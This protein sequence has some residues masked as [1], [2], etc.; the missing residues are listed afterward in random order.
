MKT[1][2]I[3]IARAKRDLSEGTDNVYWSEL[4]LDNDSD[5]A[6][7]RYLSAVRRAEALGFSYRSAHDLKQL[8]LDDIVD[9]FE[10][11]LPH[12]NDRQI[13]D[14]PLGVEIAPAAVISEAETIRL[15]EITPHLLTRKSP[16]Q[17]K[18]WLNERRSSIAFLVAQVGDKDIFA[19]NR[20]DALR[21]YRNLINMVLQQTGKTARSASWA[22][23]HLG[24]IRKFI[25]SY[26]SHI[27]QPDRMN[28]FSCL[29][30]REFKATRPPFSVK[31]ICEK[32]LIP[33]ALD[34]L[35][36]EAK[37]ILLTL[38]DTGARMGE[39]CSLSAENTH[40]DCDYPYIDIKPRTDP[41]NPREIK[42]DSSI[43]TVP[44]IGLALTAMKHNPEG[45][46]RY[47]DK[48]T[49]LSNTLNKHF[50]QNNLFETENHVICSFRHSFEDRMKEA[51]INPELRR[52]LMGH[53]VDRPK[54]GS[55]GRLR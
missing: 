39:I 46:H 29:S 32:I 19:I 17:R 22:N 7:T 55:G 9:R 21:F 23:R 3:A 38:I 11:L 54:Y 37:H 5:K 43:R 31:W 14:S 27:S 41:D 20:D 52:A 26:F 13:R 24:N 8:P 48:E 35:N 45:F 53:T 10:A 30:F 40:L 12:R 6:K 50:R 4:I 34:G 28:P 33:G 49:G 2:D 51:D 36:R 42:T 25:E 15:R 47:R 18:H 1:S 44:L 16:S